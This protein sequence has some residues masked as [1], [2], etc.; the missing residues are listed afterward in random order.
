MLSQEKQPQVQPEPVLSDH[1]QPLESPKVKEKGKKKDSS[2]PRKIQ[3]NTT[4]VQATKSKPQAQE[5]LQISADQEQQRLQEQKRKQRQTQPTEQ[6]QPHAARVSP[7]TEQQQVES[8]EPSYEQQV[9]SVQKISEEPAKVE[10]GLLQKHPE[11]HN[12]EISPKTEQAPTQTEK[13]QR[14]HVKS[15]EQPQPSITQH[16]QTAP[17]E[18]AAE[19]GVSLPEPAEES[20]LVKDVTQEK[21]KVERPAEEQPQ[22]HEKVPTEQPTGKT[23][24]PIN[25]Q[26]KQPPLVEQEVP[27]PP[28]VKESPVVHDEVQI[29]KE[30]KERPKKQPQQAIPVK[31][32]LQ[33]MPD[34]VTSQSE[35]KQSSRA[36]H[37]T[38]KADLHAQLE[39]LPESVLP[40][41]EELQ[42]HEAP[43][44]KDDTIQE[45]AQQIVAQPAPEE[46]QEKPRTQEEHPQL[47]QRK[48]TEQPKEVLPPMK[49]SPAENPANLAPQSQVKDRT[50]QQ[51]PV[52][53]RV[54]KPLP[55]EVELQK[56]L[57]QPPVQQLQAD[58]PKPQPPRSEDKTREKPR[59]SHEE[60]Q[61]DR[62]KKTPDESTVSPVQQKVEAPQQDLDTLPSAKGP[63]PKIETQQVDVVADTSR[64]QEEVEDK[65]AVEHQTLPHEDYQETPT[66]EE[67]V[68]ED[69]EP[70]QEQQ[71]HISVKEREV[72]PQEQVRGLKKPPLIHEVKPRQIQAE[73]LNMPREQSE[74]AQSTQ[75]IPQA[76]ATLHL[77]H[78]I[79][80]PSLEPSQTTK[81][82]QPDS[83]TPP[84][85]PEQV[86]V[87]QLMKHDMSI[88]KV[89]AERPQV[90]PVDLPFDTA[91]PV[92][93]TQHVIE[94]QVPRQQQG[95]VSSL[96]Q[97][98]I[99]T[100]EINPAQPVAQTRDD[101]Q[102]H[103]KPA[104]LMQNNILESQSAQLHSQSSH[105]RPT[106]QDIVLDS[107]IKPMA[108]QDL[109]SHEPVQL[110][111][112]D[113]YPTYELLQSIH[114][115]QVQEEYA[116]SVSPK[117]PAQVV[118]P[119][120]D[121]ETAKSTDKKKKT[122][123]VKKAKQPQASSQAQVTE[124]PTPETLTLKPTETETSSERVNEA[125]STANMYENTKFK[126]VYLIHADV[127]VGGR[128]N[129]A[130]SSA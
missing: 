93:P 13:L 36:A 2:L 51:Q 23:P 44:N 92:R 94:V 22:M 85:C 107:P 121:T 48:E 25:V 108:T 78:I 24:E 14:K 35:E 98:E 102:K 69:H 39:P 58:Q 88:S 54:P 3:P 126:L 41:S 29:H 55:K 97:Q 17:A 79:Q 100:F 26:Q 57:E 103:P 61:L 53:R 7:Q 27:L 77:Q 89:D 105:I 38:S 122:K 33:K 66:R 111:Q 12:P 47:I 95:H 40:K 120:T 18:R 80:A 67:Q 60:K 101:A 96:V 113:T 90:K 86:Q 70:A 118:S 73:R 75:H 9:P 52:Q 130:Q 59:K 50:T 20:T 99:A 110:T 46:S 4:K 114:P 28:P 84:A 15:T 129:Y 128:V 65:S 116:P 127:Y 72:I 42:V 11:Q 45:V 19:K 125:V 5:D 56:E 119:S 74:P 21:K 123:I 31:P 6:P 117:E 109:D 106:H 34:Q 64:T 82:T 16:I 1:V 62:Q 115:Q 104:S 63:E 43:F 30:T 49:P 91:E 10:K 83:H 76:Q 32:L 124:V 71:S 68:T 87:Q 8:V 112:H 37:A 81:F